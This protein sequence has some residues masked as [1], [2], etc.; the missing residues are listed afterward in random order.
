MPK[1]YKSQ[2]ER[3]SCASAT[4]HKTSASPHPKTGLAGQ[5]RLMLILASQVL[6]GVYGC[7][8]RSTNFVNFQKATVYTHLFDCYLNP[9]KTFL[10]KVVR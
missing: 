8:V 4:R 6:F 2:S 10:G 3:R 9:D 7:G 5:M 1:I